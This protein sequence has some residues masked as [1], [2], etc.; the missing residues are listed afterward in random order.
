MII[1]DPYDAS[2]ASMPGRSGAF[3][4]G[5]VL[6][7][8][9]AFRESSSSAPRRRLH[10]RACNLCE[11]ICGLEIELADGVISA[12]R[13]DR[14]DPFS[15]GHICPKA[16]ALQ[17][18]QDDPDRLRRPLLRR[19]GEWTELDWEE[20]LD[21]AAAGLQ[22]VQRAHG[23][24][25]AAL[26]LGNPTVHNLGA[27]LFGPRFSRALASRNRFSATSVDQLPHQLVAY[28]MFGHQL[29]LPIP[30]VDRT[31]LFLVFGANPLAS[32]G[33]LMTAPGMKRRLKELHHRGG[34]LVVV[35]PRRTETAEVADEH[36]FIR[37]GTDALMLLAM[38]QV[39]FREDLVAPGAL[40]A[41]SGVL[42]D[43]ELEQIAERVAPFTPEAVAARVGLDA[44]VMER[45]A[46]ELA[47][48]E[49]AVV[50]GRIGLSVQSF[51]TLCQ[52]AVNV[53]N[54]LTGHLDQEGGAM[55]TQPAADL[56]AAGRAR[57]SFG[58]WKSRV[59]GLPEFAGEL[60]VAAL[61]E[62]I[63][64][65]GEGRIRA[66][67]TAAGNPVLSTP[68]GRLLDAALAGLDFMVS[69]DLYL[70]ETT[71]HA[72]LILPPT[73]PLEREHYDLIFHLLAVRNTARYSPA[74]FEPEPEARHDWQ[75]FE[76][77]AR[78]LEDEEGGA[79]GWGPRELLDAALRSSP[80]GLDLA[81]VEAAPHGLDLGPLEP[82]L[83]QRLATDDGLIR[84]LPPE[85]PAELERARELL[86][87]GPPACEGADVV[88]IG[89]RHVRSN[90]SW[91]HNYHRLVKGPQRCTLW[92]HP[93]DA[94]AHGLD[95]GASVRVASRVGEVTV[96]L[97]VT[98]GIRPGV[99]S[100]PHGWG[101]DRPGTRLEVARRH[102]GVSLNDLTDPRRVDPASGNAAL[103]GVPV[104]VAPA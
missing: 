79:A 103:S 100:L 77:L 51:G 22:A 27:M 11:A 32:N 19:D 28:R 41:P 99:V 44:S 68:G 29:L 3:A 63:A 75:I 85:I 91:M 102:A 16:V 24:D 95:D 83:A 74:L 62:E 35:D 8:P 36:H 82:C 15:Q 6:R 52:W 57:G 20:A 40:G 13:G 64:T 39:L 48:T 9:M 61:A 17:D 72:D 14:D 31:D 98:D 104:T 69:V 55:F 23:R 47:A 67:V 80:R 5:A 86:G 33:S 50:Y 94:E 42:G 1:L 2:D 96:P 60:P 4:T 49:R 56:V 37:P 76:E 10:Y 45:L 25:A 54:L 92:M 89:R 65:P 26:Y 46:R 58:R 93:R 90:N 81:T 88:L 21:R 43:G 18:I 38:I 87:Q 84:A 34:R 71:R 73:P 30:D 97:E 66:L 70:N 101:H 59:R 53:L 78:R 7:W 12:I